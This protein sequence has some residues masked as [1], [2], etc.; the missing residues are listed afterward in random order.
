EIRLLKMHPGSWHDPIKCSLQVISLL[1]QGT[2]AP[3]PYAALSYVWG[4]EKATHTVTIDG[5]DVDTRPNLYTALRRLRAHCVETLWVDA[6]CIN[7]ASRQE[8]GWQV[9]LMG[10]I[11]ASAQEV[12][13]WMG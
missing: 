11:Y 1:F 2:S 7:Q 4:R 13:I 3:P 6:L 10:Y 12:C 9:N 5:F 8:R